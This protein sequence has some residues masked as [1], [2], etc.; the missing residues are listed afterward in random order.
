MHPV[1]RAGYGA[2]T[3]CP[4]GCPEKFGFAK[5]RFFVV[6]A[7]ALDAPE[8]WWFDSAKKELRFIPPD[9]KSPSSHVVSV[10]RRESAFWVSAVSDITFS[11]LWN[12][13][14]CNLRFAASHRVTVDD[15]RFI[16][17]SSLREFENMADFKENYHPI[18]LQGDGHVIEHSEV[19][20]ALET[21]LLLEGS[22]NRI[23]DCIVPRQQPGRLLIPVLRSASWAC[24]RRWAPPRWRS[25]RGPQLHNL[26]FWRRGNLRLRP[27]TGA[28]EP[29]SSLQ[30][31]NLLHGCL[32]PLHPDRRADGW[33]RS[34][35]T[36]GSTTTTASGF[37]S[38][39]WDGASPSITTWSGTR[40]PAAKSRA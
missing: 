3:P 38:T 21:G 22:G 33:D 23:E 6:A 8:E 24:R 15:C 31:R 2:R 18:W 34:S 1:F 19:S 14:G 28:G 17:P 4:S 7:G 27:G 32:G 30:W 29:Q 25:A 9:G 16:Y 11:G 39:N 40:S 37:G 35:T 20:W 26:H 36:I 5:N 13:G 12:L 10:Q